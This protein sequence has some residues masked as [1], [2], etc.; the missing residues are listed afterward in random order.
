[1]KYHIFSIATLTA[2][3]CLAFTFYAKTLEGRKYTLTG[4]DW[5]KV[6]VMEQQIE[7]ASGI[8]RKQ[9]RNF[10][11]GRELKSDNVLGDYGI[12]EGSEVRVLL[13]LR[14]DSELLFVWAIRLPDQ[15]SSCK[16][17]EV[18]QMVTTR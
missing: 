6:S 16:Y 3:V 8:P 12:H 4:E 14:P 1:M 7:Q 2:Q 11:N 13:R 9:Q 5:T 15:H 17:L 10:F 18:K